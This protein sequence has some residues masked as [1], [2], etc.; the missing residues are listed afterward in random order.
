MNQFMCLRWGN[1]VGQIHFVL[2][3]II[4]FFKLVYNFWEIPGF[5]YFCEMWFGACYRVLTLAGVIMLLLL[6]SKIPHPW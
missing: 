1:F 6:L 4:F 2:N 3:K 5:S